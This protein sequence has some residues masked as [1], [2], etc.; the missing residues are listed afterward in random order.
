MMSTSASTTADRSRTQSDSAASGIDW[1]LI[2][3]IVAVIGASVN[4][5]MFTPTEIH[6]GVAQKIFYLHV[7]AAIMGLYFSVIPMAIVSAMYLWL[8]DERLDRVAESFAEVGLVF[9]TVVLCTG[10][11]WGKPVW[12]TY[13]QWE[14]RL[15]STLFLSFVLVGYLVMRGAIEQP[16]SRARLSAIIGIM[17]GFLVPFIHLTVYMF[18]SLHPMPVVIKPEKATM[19]PEMSHSFLFS[20]SAFF[21]L[22]LALVRNRTRWATERDRQQALEDER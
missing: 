16:E 12:G 20:L 11:F 17:A 8:K 10:P 19:S 14:A 7:P 21:L 22:M 4:V 9:V 13:W 2:G 3:A 6:Q 15:T 1:L 18:N 5:L